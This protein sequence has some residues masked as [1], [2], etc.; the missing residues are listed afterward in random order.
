[1]NTS[2]TYVN[3]SSTM[4]ARAMRYFPKSNSG[5]STNNQSYFTNPL[6]VILPTHL[7]TDY[8]EIAILSTS[9]VI[10]GALNIFALKHLLKEY[11]ASN[12]LDFNKLDAAFNFHKI[13]L[14]IS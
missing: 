1:M 4:T 7:V 9:M 3:S 5:H 12:W 14:N 8:I 10:G 11:F 6:G 2:D 13:N